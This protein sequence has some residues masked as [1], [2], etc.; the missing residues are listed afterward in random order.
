MLQGQ[1]GQK[2]TDFKVICA[3]CGVVIRRHSSKDSQG[4]CQECYAG[5]LRDYIYTGA[6]Q[7]RPPLRASER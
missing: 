5:M 2:P 7:A 6:S 4:M 1:P 3:W